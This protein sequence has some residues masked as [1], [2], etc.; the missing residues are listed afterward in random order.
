MFTELLINYMQQTQWIP[1]IS[2]QPRMQFNLME[3]YLTDPKL[4]FKQSRSLK[5]YNLRLIKSDY[6]QI[7]VDFKTNVDLIYAK[8]FY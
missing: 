4:Y 5:K 2:Y 6:R 3:F 7:N 1:P 8:L